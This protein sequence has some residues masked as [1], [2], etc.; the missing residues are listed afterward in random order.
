MGTLVK[1]AA[2]FAVLAVSGASVAAWEPEKPVELVVSAGTSSGLD[3]MAR[4][5]QGIVVKHKL[6][7]QD[8]IVL[9]K[10]GGAGAES[11]ILFKRGMDGKNVVS[12]G[13]PHRIMI[14]GTNIFTAPLSTGVP[15]NWQDAS[16][17]VM[18]ALEPY[19]LW[20]NSERGYKSAK[21]YIDAARAASPGKMK[22]AGTAARQDAQILT[23]LVE[24]HSD[25][26]FSYLPVT[27]TSESF[28]RGWAR[29]SF[30]SAVSTPSEVASLWRTGELTPQCV[31]DSVR[32]PYAAKVTD[33]HS[34]NDI[35][36]CKEAGIPVAYQSSRG[37]FMSRQAS[38]EQVA[39]FADVLKKVTLT[40]EWKDYMAQGAFT[41]IFLTGPALN[42][43]YVKAEKF[44][45]ELVDC[46][47]MIHEL[48]PPPPCPG[49]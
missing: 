39:Y 35:P 28:S 21:E 15:F 33:R 37:I 20:T 18:V 44:Y 32:L 34:W 29:Q 48:R 2:L 42:A 5:I 40:S 6:M 1:L 31:F 23:I 30:D 38:A 45:K 49:G 13:D 22:M 11:F 17:V 43:R 8:L 10:P 12:I 14:V 36:T 47:F 25:A 26:K 27:G 9:N 7:K 16:P 46:A 4:V 3:Q 24:K 41:P 19:I